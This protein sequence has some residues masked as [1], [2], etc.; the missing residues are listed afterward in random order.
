M[1]EKPKVENRKFQNFINFKL[2][3][4]EVFLLEEKEIILKIGMSSIRNIPKLIA[5]DLD[6]TVSDDYK[7]N[8]LIFINNF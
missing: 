1:M 3:I 6:G 7:A 2:L 5:F 8:F 4:G